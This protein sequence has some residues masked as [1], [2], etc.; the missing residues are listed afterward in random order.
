ME[1]KS[2]K[3]GS[4][5]LYSGRFWYYKN[6][7]KKSKYK[8]GFE[9][10]KDAEN[11]CIDT[12]RTLKGL[13]EGADSITV[14]DF[15]EKWIKTKENKIAPTT[16]RGYETN[17]EHI[18][19]YLGKTKLLKL[20]LIDVQGMLDELTKFGLKYR[21]VKYV[22]STL[23]AALQYALKNDMVQ[24]NVS[25][26][27]E[28]KEDDEKF[29]ISVYSAADLGTLIALLQEQDHYLYIPVLLAAM[30]GLRR[31]E[32]LGLRWSDIDF[33]KGMA[34]IRNNYVVVKKEKIHKKVKTK[35]SQ[36]MFDIE[37]FLSDVLKRYKEKYTSEGRIQTYVCE[38][39]GEL[40]DPSHLSRQL[41]AF[42]KANDL[43]QCRFHDLRHTFAVL[44]LEAG[45]DLDT[46]KRLLGHSKIGITSDTY[47]HENKTLIKKA[48]SKIDNLVLM[49]QKSQ[50]S[51]MSQ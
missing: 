3:E 21:T 6:G 7:N 20:K 5:T 33:E 36:R 26:G 16:L 45:T 17:I 13:D 42:Q 11:W 38:I 12:E 41:K 46:L 51:E 29:E 18:N 9:K 43:P 27:V 28:I 1:I 8:S 4:K 32:C 35:E 37:G 50:K 14:K 48:S 10:K 31:G 23:H 22:H 2:Y 39:D 15:L 24:K 44:Q 34:Y 49:P 19:K 25:N 30:R 40:Q 47:L